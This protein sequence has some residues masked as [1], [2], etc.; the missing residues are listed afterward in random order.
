[1]SSQDAHIDS[2]LYSLIRS[3][4]QYASSADLGVVLLVCLDRGPGVLV[5]GLREEMYQGWQD[6]GVGQLGKGTVRLA[7]MLPTLLVGVIWPSMA[8][9]M[10]WLRY[11]SITSPSSEMQLT[12]RSLHTASGDIREMTELSTI[13]YS[14]SMGYVA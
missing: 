5:R 3:G 4:S 7:T 1:V 12:I 9:Q 2:P 13:V 11:A 8:F 6:G 10:S 14:F